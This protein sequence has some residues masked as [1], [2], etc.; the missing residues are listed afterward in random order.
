MEISRLAGKKAPKEIL[1]SIPKLISAYYTDAPS[2][3]DPGTMVSFGTSGHRGSS[4][5]NSFNETHILAICQA[6][7][8]IRKKNRVSGPLFLGMD[9]H[10]LSEPAIRTA[11]EVLAAN[12]AEIRIQENFGFT[13]TPVVSHAILAWN[14]DNDAPADGIVITPSHNPPEDGGIKYNPPSGGPASPDI[15]G[16]VQLRANE[17]I[18]GGCKDVKRLPLPR[19]IAAPTTKFVDYIVPY[20]SDLRNVVNMKA[21]ASAR[22]RVGVDPMGGSGVA[23]WEPIADMYGLD[24]QII[25]K[26]V[27]PT[28]SFMTVDWDGKIRMDCSSPHAMA[29]L[30]ANKERYAISFGNDTDFDRHGIVTGEGLMKPNAY[31]AVAANYLMTRRFG[32]SGDAQIGKTLVSSSIID[33][34]AAEIGRKVCEVPVGFK[35]FVDG[36]ADGSFGFAGEESAGASFLRTDGTTWTTDKDGFIMD[37]LAAEI[38]AVTDMSPSRIY[39]DMTARFGKPFYERIDAPAT[40][41]RKA[42]IKKLSP[43][44]VRAKELAGEPIT[45]LM[46]KAPGNG[47][48]IDGLKVTTENGWFAARPSGTEDVYKIYAESFK[49]A[50][51][52][53]NIQEEARNIV[54]EATAKL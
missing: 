7:A 44:C 54:S 30:L 16:P 3:E 10:A 31:L 38:L 33:R 41:E 46:T 52:L 43:S 12:G 17:L 2:P 15:T 20:V 45:A 9:T 22:I 6:V 23:F 37:L 35:W 29:G 47:Q 5:K 34:I 53:K 1:A 42:A 21:I 13:P 11:I 49:S 26:Y 50:E 40:P 28:F 39:M 19:A 25:N 8:E 24:L 36:L 51:H 27:D 48:P 14:R 4:L 32:W 18:K